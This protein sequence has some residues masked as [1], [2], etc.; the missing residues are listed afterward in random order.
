MNL[1]NA[2]IDIY[3][4]LNVASTMQK[5]A[6][7]IPSELRQLQIPTK[8]FRDSLDDTQFALSIITKTASKM[9]KFPLNDKLN[10]SLSNEYFELNHPKLPAE[11]QKIA[12]TYIK[13]ACMRF[14]LEPREAVKIAAADM[15]TMTNIYFSRVGDR[16]GGEL[17]QKVA[18]DQDKSAYYYALTKTAS[19][20][21]TE[22]AYALPN[23]EAIKKAEVYFDKYAMQFK[24]EDRH[25]FASNVV[26]R[27][28][29]LGVDVTSDMVN[30]Y[31]GLNYNGDVEAYLSV[32]KK[33]LDG[34]TEYTDA[35]DKLA[36]FQGKEDPKTFARVLHEFDKKAGL[37][38]YY[39]KY[40][41]DPYASTFGVGTEK[42]ASEI[43]EIDGLSVK[44]GDIEKVANEKYSLLEN[45]FGST[46]AD[47]LK[48]EGSAAFVAL[49]DNA[50]E[51]I[52]RIIHGE[53]Q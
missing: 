50:K 35:L 46:L 24:P 45:Y 19:N 37:V 11:A 4:D 22:R 17:V 51:V 23:P 44:E 48:K 39:D 8:D 41:A 47:G 1:E 43:Y 26:N 10:T 31:A 53:I 25:Q 36:S 42:T 27:A 20:G 14:G 38:R 15:P 18:S 49:P 9:N 5:V 7:A 40:L 29:E 21:H 12:A 28:V 6:S 32:R 16:A 30:K 52:A 2:V 3:D 34:R 33:L 13:Q